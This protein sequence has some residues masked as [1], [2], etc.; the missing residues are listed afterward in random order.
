MADEEDNEL[1]DDG[2]QSQEE[3][4]AIKL[5]NMTLGN[6]AN[7]DNS[8]S[9]FEQDRTDK[10]TDDEYERLFEETSKSK[11][12]S[13]RAV[14]QSGLADELGIEDIYQPIVGGHGRVF[15]AAGKDAPLVVIEEDFLVMHPPQRPLQENET[16]EA[17]TIQTDERGLLL[18]EL[19]VVKKIPQAKY[20]GRPIYYCGERKEGTYRFY[21]VAE[22]WDRS[23][24]FIYDNAIEERL[25]ADEVYRYRNKTHNGEIGK[26]PSLSST[27]DD[28]QQ[29]PERI[30]P[31]SVT[32]INVEDNEG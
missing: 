26:F 1:E 9:D 19:G 27:L 15:C 13:A 31:D 17:F 4:P 28:E 21:A 10:T 22:D 6:K 8:F 11:K 18:D 14:H 3:T 16:A 7:V 29:E 12:R 2:S 24:H 5:N 25:T 20:R 23:L 30:D 32:Q